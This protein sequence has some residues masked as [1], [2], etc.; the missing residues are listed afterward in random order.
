L[1][2]FLIPAP[3]YKQLL[4]PH[5]RPH[6]KLIDNNIHGSFFLFVWNMKLCYPNKLRRE[7]TQCNQFSLSFVPDWSAWEFQEVMTQRQALSLGLY[8]CGLNP[9][10]FSHSLRLMFSRALKPLWYSFSGK[11]NIGR[12]RKCCPIY[13]GF[14]IR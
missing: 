3:R 8:Y 7:P 9:M 14:I 2:S 6:S 10:A 5:A 12:R 1:T 4:F 11:Y 13:P